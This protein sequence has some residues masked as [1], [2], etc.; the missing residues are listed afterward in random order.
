MWSTFQQ[1]IAVSLG[2]EVDAGRLLGEVG[3]EG[4]IDAVQVANV[5]LV[6]LLMSMAQN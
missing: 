5:V 2:G 1:T 6:S 4:L 3:A